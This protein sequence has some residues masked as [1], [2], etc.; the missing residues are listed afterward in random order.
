MSKRLTLHASCRATLYLKGGP[1]EDRIVREIPLWETPT[2]VTEVVL[3]F[4]SFEE[5]LA[6]YRGWVMSDSPP[7][8]SEMHILK[9]IGAMTFEFEGW[10]LAWGCVESE[11]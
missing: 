6:A 1:V 2:K 9:V 10:D 4:E 11:D 3:S 8:E 7:E 5:K